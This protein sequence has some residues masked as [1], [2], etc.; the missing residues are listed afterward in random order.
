MTRFAPPGNSI[1]MQLG[2][3]SSICAQSAHPLDATVVQAIRD[4]RVKCGSHITQSHGSM[5]PELEGSAQARDSMSRKLQGSGGEV[6]SGDSNCGATWHSWHTWYSDSTLWCL[7]VAWIL[8][9]SGATDCT[10]CGIAV[11]DYFWCEIASNSGAS[12]LGIG[13]LPFAENYYGTPGCH[14]QDN[15]NFQWNDNKHGRGIPVCTPVCRVSPMPPHSSALRRFR[16]RIRRPRHRPCLRIRLHLR[17]PRLSPPL[18]TPRLPPPLV[19]LSTLWRASVL[20]HQ[21]RFQPPRW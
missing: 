17:L 10:G 2:T 9:S 14:I 1:D 19:T 21:R 4:L 3:V 11:E 15:S 7:R 8:A 6:G 12:E 20:L 5:P 13:T 16:L 18:V